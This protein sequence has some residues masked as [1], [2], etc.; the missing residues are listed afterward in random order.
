MTIHVIH[1]MCGEYGDQEEWSVCA[2]ISHKSALEFRDELQEA[3][4]KLYQDA[5]WAQGPDSL[6]YPKPSEVTHPLDPGWDADATGTRYMV[7]PVELKD[8]V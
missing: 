2:F 3:S 8:F 1:G 6:K 7:E 4:D 5:G